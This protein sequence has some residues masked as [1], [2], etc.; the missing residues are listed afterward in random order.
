MLQLA[1]CAVSRSVLEE[2]AERERLAQEQMAS[3]N[4][5]LSKSSAGA[6]LAAL[7]AKFAQLHVQTTALRQVGFLLRR[8]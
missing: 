2:V 3:R 7:P 5:A 6:E 8:A 1:A 4:A